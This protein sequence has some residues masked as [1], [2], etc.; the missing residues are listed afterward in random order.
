MKEG[1]IIIPMFF[2]DGLNIGQVPGQ[3]PKTSTHSVCNRPIYKHTVFA[4][5]KFMPGTGAPRQEN[6]EQLEDE[7]AA[8]R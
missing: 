1:C 6:A 7:A 5:G 4:E 8:R 2:W 3:A